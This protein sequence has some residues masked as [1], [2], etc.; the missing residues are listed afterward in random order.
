MKLADFDYDLPQGR[1]AF[2]PAQKRDLSRLLVYSRSS[3]EV[4][5]KYF[6]DLPDFLNENDFLVVNSTRV[7][8]ARLFASKAK[9]G[10]KVELLLLK[11]LHEGLWES[12][13]KPGRGMRAGLE[14]RFEENNIS[15]KVIAVQPD[16]SRLLEF[17]PPHKVY[18][19]MESI[20]AI[21]LPPYI[22]R[23]PEDSDYDRYQTVYNRNPG[24]VAAPTAGLHFTMELMQQIKDKGIEIVELVLDIGW[25]TFQPVREEDPRQHNLESERCQIGP[26]TAA[27]IKKLKQMGKNLVAVGTTS[28]RALE[29]WYQ[30]T[31]GQ[32]EP[33]Q[34][35][36]DLFIY[37]PYQ[38]KLVDKLVTNFHLPKST[39][40]MLVSAFAGRE[41]IM[42]LYRQAVEKGYRFF[43]YGDSMLIL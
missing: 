32:L 31:G 10:G 37:P 16:G 1:I 40:L 34:M 28:V 11:P 30:H 29:G 35:N 23:E 13:V 6:A 41:Q 3:Q 22:R 24:S 21:P 15:A 2:Y 33:A 27:R 14:L 42:S 25:G 12:L 43:S 20:G 5:H 8:K 19:L 7:L 36:T 38:F 39:L 26:R 9:T 18:D 4:F 17:N